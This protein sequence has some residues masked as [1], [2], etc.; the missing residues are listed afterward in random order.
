M[1]IWWHRHVPVPLL[2]VGTVVVL[3]LFLNDET[4]VSRNYEYQQEIVRL[5]EEIKLNND[6]ADFYKTK[7]EALRASSPELE[8]IAR[9]QYHMQKA[10]EEVYIVK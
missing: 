4:S 8:H 5:K 6:S 7:R 9:E 1:R 10:D 3:L 2:M